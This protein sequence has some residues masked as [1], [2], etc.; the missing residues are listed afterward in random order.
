M[1]AS[2]LSLATSNAPITETFSTD[3]SIVLTTSNA[4]IDVNIELI[5]RHPISF[6]RGLV[7]NRPDYRPYVT[8]A[9]MWT[10]NAPLRVT[11]DMA[12]TA[13]DMG[14]FK[15]EGVTS[16]GSISAFYESSPDY[17]LLE[18]VF[19]TSN[20]RVDVHHPPAYE[21]SI[22]AQTTKHQPVLKWEGDSP[23]GDGRRRSLENLIVGN[24]TMEG[25]IKLDENM[26]FGG[27]SKVI[28][29]NASIEI[30]V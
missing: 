23:A 26:H 9:H 20:G 5:N 13:G 24:G 14:P 25:R 10:S 12:S 16:N 22:F 21:G 2:R 1:N 6:L 8:K 28:T 18:S 27:T 3:R 7:T 11:L 19:K 4:T 30:R 15:V 17:L 29:T